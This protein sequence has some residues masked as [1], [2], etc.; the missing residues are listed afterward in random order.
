MVQQPK[1]I[2][3]SNRIFIDGYWSRYSEIINSALDFSCKIRF[4]IFFNRKI[5]L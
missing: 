1:H 5:A 3:V 2:K 4:E